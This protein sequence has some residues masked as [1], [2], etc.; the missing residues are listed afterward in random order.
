MKD[1]SIKELIVNH[2]YFMRTV[3]NEML[4][5]VCVSIIVAI[6]IALLVAFIKDST[7][8]IL[9]IAVIYLVLFFA[10]VGKIKSIHEFVTNI[11]DKNVK[12]SVH[13]TSSEYHYNLFKHF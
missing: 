10:K 6:V 4:G 12:N 11:E 13:K 5:F 1:D 2:N 8:A 9:V 7:W 3:I